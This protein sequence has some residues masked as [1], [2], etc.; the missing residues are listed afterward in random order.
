MVLMFAR[1]VLAKRFVFQVSDSRAF[2]IQVGYRLVR[3]TWM[4]MDLLDPYY[5]FEIV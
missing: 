5:L 2:D 4:H 3:W 1:R